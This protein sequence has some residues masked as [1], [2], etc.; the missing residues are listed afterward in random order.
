[1][2]AT[3]SFVGFANF[4]F[5]DDLREQIRLQTGTMEKCRY[6]AGSRGHQGAHGAVFVYDV[7]P[8]G[9]DTER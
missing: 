4:L 5:S 1:M 3:S 9:Y 2:N 8:I 6:L 7:E